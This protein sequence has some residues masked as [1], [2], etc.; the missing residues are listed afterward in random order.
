VK[1]INVMLN[2]REGHTLFD[3]MCVVIRLN[4]VKS[5]SLNGFCSLHMNYHLLTVIVSLG[6]VMINR[7]LSNINLASFSSGIFRD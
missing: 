1:T 6:G 5:Y 3:L 7:I 2:L 4:I